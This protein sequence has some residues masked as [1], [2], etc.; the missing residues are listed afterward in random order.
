MKFNSDYKSRFRILKGGKIALVISVMIGGATISMASPSGGVVTTGSA[1]ISQVGNTTNI[2]Q[3]TSKATIN[4]NTFNVAHNE[5]VN[6]NQPSINS[7]TLNR[8]IGNERSIINGALNANGQVWILNS[9]GVLFGNTAKIN[10]SGLLVTTKNLSDTDFNTNNYSFKGDSTNSV[11]N[12]GTIDI[13]NKGY[14]SLI[15]KSVKNEGTITATKGTIHLVGAN[16]VSINLNGNSMLNLTI[17]KGV[18]DAIVQNSGSL[19]ANAGEVYLTTNAVNDLLKG[20]VNNTGIIEAQSLGDLK[21][22]IE[23]FAHGGEVQVGGTLKAKDGF[24]ETSGKDFTI[25]ENTIIQTGL[26][27]IDPTNITINA[28]LAS[29]LQTQLA[30]GDALVTTSSGNAD[31]GDIN[32]NSSIAWSTN[33]LTL[34]ADND[35][36]INATLNAS[37]TAGLALEYAQT[38][39]TGTYN[40]SASVNLAS[41][42]SFST[43]HAGDAVKNYTIINSLGVAGSTTRTDL[44]GINGN[45]SGNYVLGSNI[46]ASTTST[47]NAGKGWNPLGNFGTRFTGTFDGLGHSISNLYINRASTHYIGLFGYADTGATV[48][49]IGLVDVDI[50]GRDWVGGLVGENDGTLSRS[51]STGIVSG[52]FYTGGLVGENDG[53]LSRSYST[54]SVSGNFFVG[55]LVGTNSGTLSRSYST[56]SVSGTDS[57]GGLVGANH[58]T[59]SKSYST[60]S[61]S[62]TVSVGGLVGMNRGTI[63]KS[64]STG[65]VSGTEYDYTG[66]LVGEKM[67]GTT[68]N[69]YWDTQTSGQATSAGG[70]GKTTVQM[71]DPNTYVGWDKTIWDLA[72]VQTQGYGIGLP[73]LLNV[74]QVSH[75]PTR[76]TLFKSGFGTNANPYG[77]TNWEQLNNIRNV[78][79][80]NFYFNLLNNIN[81]ST[82]NYNTYASSSAN[83][84]KGWNPLG[85]RSTKFKGKFNGLGNS[86]SNLYIDRAN[87]DFI[88]LFGHVDTGTTITK[89]G[90]VDADIKGR[91]YV[92]GLVGANYGTISNSY[93]TG[94]VSGNYT[95]G[96]LV[97][98][99]VG[100]I[101]NS[102]STG[103][104]SGAASIGGLVGYNDRGT[105]SNSY[106][107]R[108][109]SGAASIGGLVGYNDRGTISNSYST[110]SVSGTA[111]VGGLVG[112]TFSGTTTNSFWDTQTSGQATS[113]G[114]TGKTTAQMKDTQTFLDAGWD[115]DTVWGRDAANVINGGYLYLRALTKATNTPNPIINGI[116][117]SITNGSVL[118]VRPQLASLASIVVFGN[119]KA[120][121]IAPQN[122][123]SKPISMRELRRLNNIKGDLRTKVYEDSSLLLVNSGIQLPKGVQQMFFLP[124]DNEL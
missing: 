2:N 68:T 109:V 31:A 76:K 112:Y 11:I 1:T 52:A 89:L 44:Q 83:A 80:N 61:V 111:R 99:N 67:G 45:L 43:K 96:G 6:F 16:E 86:I 46:D 110:G 26:W 75:R 60:G 95:T 115:L 124:K 93:S 62:G 13:S 71:K 70:T 24:I 54:G 57:T 36:N 117:A 39:P 74:T 118:Q 50:T 55:G 90:L 116:V 32:V 3:S 91:N 5:T 119:T 84:G 20:V 18:L 113:A 81:S 77:I 23:L 65:R 34:R 98:L 15:A 51:Y 40:I 106:S 33:T 108:S 100:T 37:S 121:V 104:V 58:G 120:L 17:D 114:G 42:G 30:S 105:I 122:Q 10:T 64:Y 79:S 9:N 97:G 73:Y 53:T 14:A 7:I 102:Y 56:G 8:V 123:A 78:L 72:G 29:T 59:I 88:G 66:G 103:S 69:S 28:A 35:I 19:Y 38:T 94:R 49:N 21:G 22:K 82:L 85:N 41:T 87:T 4:W 25:A 47:W 101:S 12:L 27:L 48:T 63:S 92:G 107:T